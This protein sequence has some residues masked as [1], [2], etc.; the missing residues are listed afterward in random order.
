M[1]QAIL[2]VLLVGVAYGQ[3]PSTPPAQPQPPQVL[4][5]F[6][7]KNADVNRLAAMV[8]VFGARVRPDPSLRVIS[9]SGTEEQVKA[10]ADAISRY[11]VPPPAQKNV[12]LTF[13]LVQALPT[14]VTD[15]L[16]SD[17]EPVIK[18]LRSTFAFQGYRL[19]DTIQVRGR[20]GDSF[21]ASSVANF[22]GMAA[23]APTTTSQLRAQ[24]V[25]I[26]STD[27]TPVIRIDNLRLGVRVPQCTNRI[28]GGDC[29]GGAWQFMENGINTS[30][31]VK[32]GQKV[33]IG[34]TAVGADSAIIII[35]TAKVVD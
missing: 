15:K 20:D 1:K 27:K 28:S 3:T 30:V 22:T 35:V 19:A 8:D 33:V 5:V 11:D 17:L 21:D 34:K 14:P 4:R 6:Q 9:V 13:Q 26:G 24:R 31:D 10:I 29:A 25:T 18:Q 7:I 16:P 23:N 32:E 12:E 2:F